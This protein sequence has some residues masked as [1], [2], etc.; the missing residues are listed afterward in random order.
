[1][2]QSPKASLERRQADNS[3]ADAIYSSHHAICGVCHH[4]M[5]CARANDSWR[6]GRTGLTG[7]RASSLSGLASLVRSPPMNEWRRSSPGV[8]GS[9]SSNAA[10]VVGVASISGNANESIMELIDERC[11]DMGGDTSCSSGDMLYPSGIVPLSLE[12]WR[13]RCAAYSSTAI[14]AVAV[15]MSATTSSGM[16]DAGDTA[17]NRGGF[18]PLPPDSLL[19]GVE[20]SVPI[21]RILKAS[22]LFK[23]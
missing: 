10:L 4:T 23:K 6:T 19:L 15:A 16:V 5:T 13:F 18:P 21:P 14:A 2:E 3:V 9:P 1:M 17:C 22:Y 20:S 12:G 11:G 7:S 8:R